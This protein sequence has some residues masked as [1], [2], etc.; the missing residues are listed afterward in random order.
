MRGRRSSRS[1]AFAPAWREQRRPAGKRLA[2]RLHR[3]ASET[4]GHLASAR[5]SLTHTVGS[6]AWLEGLAL[7]IEKAIE[8]AMLPGAGPGRVG[9]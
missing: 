8:E 1:G 4:G 7:P 6:D 5:M 9:G 2:L 3:G